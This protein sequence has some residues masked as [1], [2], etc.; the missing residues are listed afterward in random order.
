MN[1][2]K[3]IANFETLAYNVFAEDD[4]NRKN[5]IDTKIELLVDKVYAHGIEPVFYERLFNSPELFARI[6]IAFVSSDRNYD[7]YK[8]L[9]ILEKT[10]KD[11]RTLIFFN[12]SQKNREWQDYF[13]KFTNT[14]LKEKI[15]FYEELNDELLFK[16]YY[17]C[18][19]LYGKYYDSYILSKKALMQKTKERI[20]LLLNSVS[21]RGKLSQFFV[22]LFK[23]AEENKSLIHLILT[24]YFSWIMKQNAQAVIE[25]LRNIVQEYANDLNPKM[26]TFAKDMINEMV[27]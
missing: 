10:K 9:E 13:A 2:E 21:D 8:S 11:A 14:Q 1:I 3:L 16:K 20:V 22:I 27:S 25:N 12:D 5:Q 24:N 26:L 18:I 23:K 19:C 17:D 15:A 6:E 4:F 7:L